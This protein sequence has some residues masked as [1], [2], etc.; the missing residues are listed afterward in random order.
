MNIIKTTNEFSISFKIEGYYYDSWVVHQFHGFSRYE[1]DYRSGG[2]IY[3]CDLESCTNLSDPKA[4]RGQ[5]SHPFPQDIIDELKI[6]IE[7]SA[8]Y[9]LSIPKPL[10]PVEFPKIT[11]KLYG[12]KFIEEK[13]AKEKAEWIREKELNPYIPDPS[14]NAMYN[15][16]GAKLHLVEELPVIIPGMDK[17]DVFDKSKINSFLM[18]NMRENRDFAWFIA[19]GSMKHIKSQLQSVDLENGEH[20]ISF[21]DYYPWN[22]F[23]GS[24]Q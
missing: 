11:F 22:E 9:Y 21:T 17:I 20:E 13:R 2:C 4:F 8:R 10:P 12:L 18:S 14:K 16:I 6:Q 3:K 1:G 7:E 23:Y 5:K 15:A 24:G 19:G